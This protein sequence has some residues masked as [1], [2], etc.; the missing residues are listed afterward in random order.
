MPALCTPCCSSPC[1]GE[2]QNFAFMPNS[3]RFDFHFHSIPAFQSSWS[4][5]WDQAEEKV[6][7][8]MIDV[9]KE[10]QGPAGMALTHIASPSLFYQPDPL[11]AYF[12]V[13]GVKKLP[14]D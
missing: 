4:L 9:L 10:D 8:G 12:T 3:R 6:V 14:L 13:Y 5:S 7:S 1:P 11:H 2:I